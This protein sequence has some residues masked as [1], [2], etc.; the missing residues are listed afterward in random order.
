[1]R[2]L[3]DPPD[4]VVDLAGDLVGVVGLSRELPPQ[5]RQPMVVAE[6]PGTQLL[7]HPEA[8]HHLLGRGGDLLEVV[9]RARRHLAEADLLGGATAQRHR[10]GVQQ[11]GAGGQEL[12]LSRQ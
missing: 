7:G 6:H 5:E 9:R 3:H 2:G 11:L 1:M 4:L 12:V 10:H 8:H